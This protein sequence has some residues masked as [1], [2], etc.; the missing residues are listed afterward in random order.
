MH[1]AWTDDAVTSHLACV[2]RT[3]E[4]FLLQF[5]WRLSSTE[6]VLVN[7]AAVCREV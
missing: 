5:R 1:E 4:I 7:V 2:V 6:T 3:S